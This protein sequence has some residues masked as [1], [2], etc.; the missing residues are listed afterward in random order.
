MIETRHLLAAAIGV[1]A[2]QVAPPAR[3]QNYCDDSKGNVALTAG[4]A[5]G[6]GAAASLGSSALAATLATSRNYNF[7]RGTLVSVGITAGLAG[8]YAIVDGSSGCRMAEGGIAWSVPITTFV[9][10]AAIPWALWGASDKSDP[11][12]TAQEQLVTL[13]WRF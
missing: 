9:V 10:G 4:V 12:A 5:A 13:G 1:S 2:V 3:A 7:T 6:A 11:T 8:I